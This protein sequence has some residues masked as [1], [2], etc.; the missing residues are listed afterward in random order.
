MRIFD[1][2]TYDLNEACLSAIG[3][4]MVCDGATTL[5]KADDTISTNDEL[6]SEYKFSIFPN[7]STGHFTISFDSREL[8][9][10]DIRISSIDGALIHQSSIKTYKQKHTESID[11]SHVNTGIYILELISGS[12]RIADKLMITAE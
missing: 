4:E 2:S 10:A 8:N 6:K 11:L 5:I 1:L 3:Q 7:P 12:V 9:R